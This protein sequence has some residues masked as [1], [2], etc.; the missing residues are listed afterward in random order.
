M[1]EVLASSPMAVMGDWHGDQG[2]ALDAI[3]SAAR[4]GASV[5]VHVGDFGLDFPGAKRGR[6]EQRLNKALVDLGVELVVSPGNHD[7]LTNINELDV[8]EDGL[9][10]WR[11]HI[12]VLPK[13]GRTSI[14]GLRV[15][16]LGGAYSIDQ[17]WRRE[18]KDW[19]AEEEPTLEQA[20]QL[21]AGGPV[22]ILI[23]HDV[24]AGVPV[25]SQLELPADVIE[26]A[27]RTRVL[28]REVVDRLTPP[29]IFAG[30]WHQRVVHEIPHLGGRISR[31]DVLDCENSRTGNGVLVWPGEPPLRIEPL[32]IKRG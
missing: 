25:R 27:D 19:W 6:Y 4:E 2:F 26:R 14:A 32:I 15:G 29:H 20:E 23:T 21:L 7:C 1:S 9:I 28:L 22:D 31:I 3:R 8:Q 16:G 24:P 11:S 10:T 13:G 18:G 17:A 12:K 30:H 5:I